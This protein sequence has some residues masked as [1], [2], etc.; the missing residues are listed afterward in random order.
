MSNDTALTLTVAPSGHPRRRL[1]IEQCDGDTY[2]VEEAR[3]GCDF[4]PVGR[5]RLTAFELELAASTP[6]VVTEP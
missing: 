1:R 5:E 3:R 2:L 6:Q 4:R